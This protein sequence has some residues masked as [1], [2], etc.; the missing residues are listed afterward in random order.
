MKLE[1]KPG[2]LIMGYPLRTESE[3]SVRLR[4]ADPAAPPIL[5]TN[6]L[7]SNY[8]RQVIIG[9]F[10]LMRKFGQQPALQALIESGTFPGSSGQTDAE[11]PAG[12]PEGVTCMHAT[13]TCRIG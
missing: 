5:R 7:A 11:L 6:F 10:R 8:D 4:S 2:M 13:A 12:C 9:M 3:G 1:S